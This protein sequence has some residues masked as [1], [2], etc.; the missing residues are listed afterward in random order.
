MTCRRFIEHRH[1][2]K[3]SRSIA[4][5]AGKLVNNKVQKRKHDVNIRRKKHPFN[6]KNMDHSYEQYAFL[7]IYFDPYL[8]NYPR[9]TNVSLTLL[10]LQQF[11]RHIPCWTGVGLILG[12]L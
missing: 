8:P 10:E 12:K 1:E 9:F 3:N 2:A 5:K 11:Y 6:G 7:Y 4:L